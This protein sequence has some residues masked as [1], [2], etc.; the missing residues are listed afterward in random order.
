MGVRGEE[1][2]NRAEQSGVTKMNMGTEHSVD[3]LAVWAGAGRG[4]WVWID[5][6][7]LKNREGLKREGAGWAGALPACNIVNHNVWIHEKHLTNSV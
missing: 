5:G 3:E 7:G 4:K 6:E 1:E 2:R